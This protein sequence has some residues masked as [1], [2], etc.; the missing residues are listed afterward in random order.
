[1]TGSI[2]GTAVQRIE[3]P[4]LLTGRTTF[5]ASLKVEGTLHLCFVRSTVAHATIDSIDTTHARSQPGVVAVY[6]ASDLA[7]PAHHAFIPVNDA[8]KRPPL[9]VDK[10]RFVGDIV[11]VVVAQ[12]EAAAVDASELVVVEYG[13]LRA[14]VDAEQALEDG[15]SQLFDALPGNLI[16]GFR[17]PENADLFATADVVVRARIENQRVAVVPMEGNAIAVVPNH[18]EGPAHTVYVSTQMPHMFRTLA[19][20]VVG[21]DP[22][23]IRVITPHVGGGFGGKAGIIAEHTVAMAVSMKLDQPVKWIE[24]RSE[25]LLNMHGRGQI[26]YAEMGFTKEGSIVGLRCRIVGDGGSYA[27]IGGA[28]PMGPSRTMA[29]GV[30]NIPAIIYEVAVAAT[31]T[32]SIGAF[33]GA[34]RPEAAALLERI[35]DLAADELHIDPIALRKRNLL[36][37]DQFPYVTLMGATY[38]NGTYADALDAAA[39]AVDYE[40]LLS[41]Q[42]A[43]RAEGGPRQLG[44][45]VS[46]YVEITGSAG[47][48]EYSSVEVHRDGSATVK[49]GTSGHGQGHP[50]TFA[51]IVSD[52]LGIPMDRIR[53]VQSDTAEVPRGSGT[54]GSRSLQIGGSSVQ[55]A[56]IAVLER[57]RQVAAALL[58]ASPEDIV[59]TDDGRVGVAGSPAT[60]LEWSAIAAVASDQGQPLVVEMDLMQTGATFPFG[61]HVAVVEVDTDTGFVRMLRHVAVDDCGRIVNPLIVE[62]QQ[63]GGIAQGAAQALWEQFVYDEDGNP[64]TSTLAEY[65]MP[66]AAEFPSFEASHTETPTHLN[67]LG[68][69]GIGESGT[70]GSMPAVQNAVIDAL[71]HLGV[72]HIDMP[73]TPQRVWNAMQDAAAGTV[74]DPWREPPAVFKRLPI[75]GAVTKP[76]DD[77]EI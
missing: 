5:I 22:A 25:N 33:R 75:R 77:V 6:T 8:C 54:G 28:L 17:D 51:M 57:G 30:Y 12:T 64:L 62:G 61:A 65:A 35:M 7:L 45:G 20:P 9:A 52:Q 48:A 37:P 43:L 67:P 24:T 66:S 14:V 53:F 18:G 49:V 59:I 31:N 63:H 76:A 1:M 58:E 34:G 44:I 23:Q 13:V 32:A 42:A 60:A 27:G 73:C 55:A 29:Q 26:Q 15:A 56:A 74:S 4:D 38:D 2:L 11:A 40:G 41:K 72:R 50:T 10:V 46:T 70:I 19:S 3:D 47:G 16:G 39:L 68:A 71:S 36:T 21:L 69:K